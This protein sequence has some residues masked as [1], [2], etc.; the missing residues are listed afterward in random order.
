MV[1]VIINCYNGAEYL[2]E[3]LNSLKRQSYKNFEVIFW[4][5]CSTDNSKEIA[6]SYGE[7][8]KYYCSSENVPLGKARNLAIQKAA[9]KYIAF[10]DSDD[11]WNPDKLKKQ[12]MELENNPDCGMVF[13][14]FMRMNML[15]GKVDVHNKKAQ[16]R[17]L[18]FEDLVGKYDFCLSSFMIREEA[19]HGLDHIFNEEF[20]YAEEFELFSRIAYKW[21]TI[22]LPEPLVTYRIHKNMNTIKFQD[23]IGIEYGIALENLVSMDPSFEKNYYQ[24]YKK[25]SFLRDFSYAK[26]IIRK[27][28]N[29]KVRILMKKYIFYNIRAMCFWILSFFPKGISIKIVKQFYKSRI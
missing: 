13:S 10:I 11:L 1:S 17:V 29:T 23:R 3:T 26:D 8:L 19:L 25:I 18:S 20:R 5:N 6:L 28:E 27:G 22:Y 15:N 24:I 14:N 21:N 2:C 16:Y 7:G 12:V 4:D 9:G